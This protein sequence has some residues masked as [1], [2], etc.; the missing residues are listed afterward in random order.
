MLA[1]K[2]QAAAPGPEPQLN[3]LIQRV[4]IGCFEDLIFDNNKRI[5]LLERRL[6]YSQSTINELDS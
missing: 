3:D 5:E 2:F 1:E 6:L 4:K